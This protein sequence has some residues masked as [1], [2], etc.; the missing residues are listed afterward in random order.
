MKFG[1]CI[2]TN[3]G[4][5]DF[6]ALVGIAPKAEEL[7]FDSVW[8]SEHLF[9]VD[10]I[11]DRLGGKPYYEPLTVLAYLASMTS[12]IRL[13]TSVLVLPYHDPVRLAKVSATLDVA[14][15]GR[16]TLGLGVGRMEE[17]YVALG[18]SFKERG[19]IANEAIQV[20]KTLWTEEDPEFKGR[21]YSFSNV[22]FSPKPLQKPHPPIWIGGNSRAAMRRAARTGDAWHPTGLSPKTVG[23]GLEYVRQQAA[24]AE[25]D[26]PNMPATLLIGW[27][28]NDTSR[29][30]VTGDG[31]SLTGAAQDIIQRVKEYESAGVETTLVN[32]STDDVPLLLHHMERFS[33]EV[34]PTFQ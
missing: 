31:G 9:N 15:R 26:N 6:G 24:K 12:T 11:R 25:R 2:P 3:M 18:I 13:G 20:M 7:G 1:I 32:I 29:R 30:G 34:L 8:V 27:D 19:A 22:K 5:E 21:Y 33:K 14:S 28:P 16:V 10:Y 23:H 17:E 4:I